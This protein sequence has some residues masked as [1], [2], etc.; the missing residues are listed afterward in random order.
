MKIA[1]SDKY[2]VLMS[3]FGKKGPK[4]GKQQTSIKGLEDACN[5]KKRCGYMP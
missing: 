4:Y 5:V 1:A 2:L 3:N